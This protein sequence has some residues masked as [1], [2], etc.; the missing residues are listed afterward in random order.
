MGGQRHP[1]RM[2]VRQ[3]NPGGPHGE[4]SL[5]HFADG[6]VYLIHHTFRQLDRLQNL[7]AVVHTDHVYHFMV[8]PMKQRDA[9]IHYIAAAGQLAHLAPAAVLIVPIHQ[10][11]GP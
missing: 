1:R 3:D 10:Q 8:H 5:H 11:H 7:Q 9:I 2:V 6:N 4:R